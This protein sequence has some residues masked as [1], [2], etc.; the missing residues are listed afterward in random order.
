[1][2]IDVNKTLS[3]LLI[4][5]VLISIGFAL[6]KELTLRR[7][8]PQPGGPVSAGARNVRGEQVV[9][10]YLH[11]TIRCVTCNQMEKLARELV[12][13][14]FADAIQ[15]GRLAWQEVDFQQNE[16]LARRFDVSSSCVVVAKVRNREIVDF[17]RLE[18]VWTLADK[19]EQFNEYIAKAIA[20]C[21]EG[22]WV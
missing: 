16:D 5:F 7:V 20:A 17:R 9:V 15:S 21:L 10:Y 6:G 3:R 12:N 8:R 2:K 13:S 18:E 14:R 11:T 22:G 19:P 4:A 1:M